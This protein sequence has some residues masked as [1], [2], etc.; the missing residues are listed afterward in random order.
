MDI[1]K[2]EAVPAARLS[3]FLPR[4]HF[5]I[6]AAASPS[7]S[8][9]PSPWAS[10]TCHTPTRASTTYASINSSKY[11]TSIVDS[12]RPFLIDS[13]GINGLVVCGIRF[14]SK[15]YH[16]DLW[17]CRGGPPMITFR[18]HVFAASQLLVRANYLDRTLVL[19]LVVLQVGSL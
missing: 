1:L 3:S 4:H 18:F 12:F 16:S 7:R 17:R 14:P 15:R 8:A 5:E 6:S 11:A 2:I 10:T 19:V 13:G 9:L